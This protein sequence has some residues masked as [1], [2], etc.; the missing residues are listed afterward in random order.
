MKIYMIG[1]AGAGMSALAQVYHARGHN[2]SGSDG[3]ETYF[4]HSLLERVGISVYRGF[5]AAHVPTDVERIV[6]S[7]AYTQ[8]NLEV[9][10]AKRRGVECMSYPEALGQLTSEYRTIA[11]CGTHGKTTTTAMIGVMLEYAG[12][13]PTVIVGSI[14]SQWGTNA[15]I[16]KSQWLVI[17]ADEYQNKLQYYHPEGVVLTTVDWD[18]PDFFP[19]PERYNQVF[20]D[21]LLR[22]PMNGWIIAGEDDVDVQDV[23]RGISRDLLGYGVSHHRLVRWMDRSLRFGFQHFQVRIGPERLGNFRLRLPGFHNVSNATAAIA[24]MHQLGVRV[25]A[26]SS[27]LATFRGTYRRLERIG[28]ER[29]VECIDDYAHHP[30]EI[31]ASLRALKEFYAPRRIVCLFQPHTY[32]RTKSLL[33]E[34]KE[35]FFDADVAL[36]TDI[37]ASARETEK[38][39]ENDTLPKS[40]ASHPDARYV[41][42]GEIPNTL[43]S[44]L[45]P[46]DVFVTMGAGNVREVATTLLSR[47]LP[48][49]Q[50]DIE[51]L[52]SQAGLHLEQNVGL[53]NLTTFRIGGSARF[54]VRIS[55]PEQ[56]LSAVAL[57]SAQELP[58]LMLAGGCNMLVADQGFSGL[59]IKSE[60]RHVSI[61]GRTVRVGSGV[62]LNYFATQAAKSGLSG[63]EFLFTIPG[64]VGGAVRGNAGAWGAEVK[65][66]L[67]R[68]R[69]WDGAA[70]KWLGRGEMQLGYRT[71]LIKVKQHEMG[72]VPW[73]ILE[74]EFEL[75]PA[76]PQEIQTKM[77]ELAFRKAKEQS[78]E[79]GS[80]GCLF[81][82]IPI[83]EE[84]WNSQEHARWKGIVPSEFLK[85]GMISAGWLIDRLDLKSFQIGKVMV[86]PKHANFL[87]N[88]GGGTAEE[89]MILSSVIKQKVRVNFGVQLHEE[90]EMVGF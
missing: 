25:S 32:S 45:K 1:I 13:D 87:V 56:L 27:A 42:W 35:A 5:D 89:V 16:G 15:R 66:I 71:S 30:K 33:A 79:F 60:D 44:L 75:T 84:F 59:V 28:E 41:P 74:A 17:E 68:V 81:T 76:D 51:S 78:L 90:V 3:V 82:N 7:T 24:V 57:A 12:F 23:T 47:S 26:M 10:E 19:T 2:V 54:L 46:L 34:F 21:F 4:T 88:L 72:V 80:A 52:F 48:K 43:E 9:A 83:T 22:V 40:M 31:Q 39:L 64:T 73:V 38:V 50:I 37:Y 86:S 6:Y 18:H 20:R 36:I 69:V 58:V 63:A 62:P 14:V 61:E 8:Q 53:A 49:A 70:D 11:V 29:G 65:D 77:Q 67:K 85:R 55:S